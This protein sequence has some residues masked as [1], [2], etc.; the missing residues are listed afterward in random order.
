MLHHASFNAR[1]PDKVGRVL[2][3][4]LGA[5]AIRAPTPPFPMN[6]WLVCFGDDRGSLIEVMPWGAVRE[7]ASAGGVGHD[8][9]MRGYSG[10]H[11]LVT[12]AHSPAHVI[13]MAQRE[14]WQAEPGSAGLFHFTKVW[15]EN[16]FLFEIMTS[17]QA[18]AYATTFKR[19]GLGDA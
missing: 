4:M 3:E 2:A 17:E 8:G 6:S 12:T 15:I 9:G 11:L 16:T 10:S 14:G 18:S 1:E 5:V 19:R 13:A 7:P